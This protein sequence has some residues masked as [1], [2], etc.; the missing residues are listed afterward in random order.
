[1]R[2]DCH[3]V[4]DAGGW[5]PEPFRG[6]LTVAN[7]YADNYISNRMWQ[8][9]SVIIISARVPSPITHIQGRASQS[10]R[11]VLSIVCMRKRFV[12]DS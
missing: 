8:H 6:L 3:R 1:M 9:T 10:I 7:Y 11:R 12:L 2:H 4:S 5:N